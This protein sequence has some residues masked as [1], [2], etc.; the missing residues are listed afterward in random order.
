MGRASPH[1]FQSIP[2]STWLVQSTAVITQFC[3]GS[4]GRAGQRGLADPELVHGSHAEPVGFSLNQIKECKSGGICWHLQVHHLP[5]IAAYERLQRK[6]WW[7]T[8][9]SVSTKLFWPITKLCFVGK[10]FTKSSK[11]NTNQSHKLCISC[12]CTQT[13]HPWQQRAP[14][15]REVRIK[16]IA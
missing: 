7:F 15:L 13:F 1:S 3:P 14:L 4:D 8:S 16:E 6:M 5:G 12:W 9:P 2:F 11:Q 10:E